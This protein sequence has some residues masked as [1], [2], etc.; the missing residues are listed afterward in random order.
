MEDK[1]LIDSD[2]AIIEYEKNIKILSLSEI[3]SNILCSKNKMFR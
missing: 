3:V 1:D 2:K